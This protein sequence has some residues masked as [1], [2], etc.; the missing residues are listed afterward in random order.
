[1]A[2][3]KPANGKTAT[4]TNNSGYSS[5]KEKLKSSP[6]RIRYGTSGVGEEDMVLFR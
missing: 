3:R 6:G 5:K 1:M 2:K 4:P